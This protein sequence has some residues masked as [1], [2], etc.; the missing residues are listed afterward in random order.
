MDAELADYKAALAAVGTSVAHAND[1]KAKLHAAIESASDK[2]GK[3]VAADTAA[4]P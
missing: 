4:K 3:Q 1:C 2:I